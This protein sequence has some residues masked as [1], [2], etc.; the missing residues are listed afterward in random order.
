MADEL[1]KKNFLNNTI[2]FLKIN[3][4]V[5]II[6]LIILFIFLSTFIFYQNNEEKKKH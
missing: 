2:N 3:L 4:K 6:L 5:F 1:L